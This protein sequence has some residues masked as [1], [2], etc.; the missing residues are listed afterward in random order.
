MKTIYLVITL[1]FFSCLEESEQP[2]SSQPDDHTME[3]KD[4]ME[5]TAD[6]MTYLALGDSYTIG[7]RVDES[8]RWPV[9]LVADLNAGGVEISTPQIIA[10]TG[11]TTNELIGAISTANIQQP[12]D[13]VSLLIG[14]NNQYRGYPIAQ[15]EEE[16]ERLLKM[17]IEFAGG[18][19]DKVFVVS[20]PDYGVTPFG[21]DRDPDKIAKEIDLYNELNKRIA[22][23][24]NVMY[25]DIT[26]ISRE[27]STKPE[28]VA[29]DGLH[30]SGE[31]YDAW[32]NLIFPGVKEIFAE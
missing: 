28:Y 16:F 29:A 25:F 32:V 27:A 14:V 19:A 24:N 20:I 23:Q 11:W 31:M 13:L 17:A 9:Q 30:P 3:E 21:Q 2:L 8:E 1:V 18:D 12:Y 6:K 7:E 5:N 22:A 15:Q 26:P 10:K 4:T